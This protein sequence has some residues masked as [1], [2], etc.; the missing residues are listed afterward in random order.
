MIYEIPIDSIGSVWRKCDFRIHM[1]VS[2]QRGGT[3]FL[4]TCF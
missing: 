1:P 2:F 3:A 4:T